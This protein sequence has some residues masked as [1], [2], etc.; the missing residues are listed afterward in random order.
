MNNNILNDLAIL[1]VRVND[2]IS[3]CIR[4]EVL[5]AYIFIQP[6]ESTALGF[7]GVDG[8]SIVD[9]WTHVI[10][11][12]DGKYHVF[13]NGRHAYSIENPTD[14]FKKDLMNRCMKSVQGAIREY[15]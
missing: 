6:W 2:T 4:A 3:K 11:T 7:S 5:D 12:T 1:T 13:F 8:S 9:A 10:Q 14:Q 15:Q